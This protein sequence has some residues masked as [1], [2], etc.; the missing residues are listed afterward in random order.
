MLTFYRDWTEKWFDKLQKSH[1]LLSYGRRQPLSKADKAKRVKVAILDTGIDLEH[2]LLKP[3]VD[4]GQIAE[5]Y[6]FTRAR[7]PTEDVHGHGTHTAHLLLKTAPN[8]SIYVARVFR[9]MTA[10]RN[11]P[12]LL[13][14]VSLILRI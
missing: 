7:V 1:D 5:T 8:A 14:E 11:T 3:Y 6:D 2:P 10:T 4:A 9:R 12:G 13:A